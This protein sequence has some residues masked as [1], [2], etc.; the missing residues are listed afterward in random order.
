MIKYIFWPLVYICLAA[1]TYMMFTEPN[2]FKHQMWPEILQDHAGLADIN[3][4][5]KQLKA[6]V[7]NLETKKQDIITDKC[8]QFLGCVIPK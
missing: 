5:F 4:R 3:F 8:P 6:R 2:I 7:E 1:F